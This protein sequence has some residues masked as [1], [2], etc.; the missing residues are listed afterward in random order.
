MVFSKVAALGFGLLACG[1]IVYSARLIP[2]VY[3]G[4]PRIKARALAWDQRYQFIISELA[5]GKKDITVPA[6]DSVARLTELK[7]DS[8]HWVNHCASWYFGAD[9]IAAIDSYTG[10][11]PYFQ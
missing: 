5:L 8:D 10:V 3:D 7:E 4:I 1:I 11:K 2:T 6:F 9:S